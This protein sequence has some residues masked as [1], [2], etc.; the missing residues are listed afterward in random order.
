MGKTA[1]FVISVLEQLKDNTTPG[2][3]ALVVAHTR[4]L[5]TQIRDEFL[6]FRKH[7]N[8]IRVAVFLGG[9]NVDQDIETLKDPP[10]IVIGTPG[11]LL[12]LVKDGVLDLSKL[13][14]FVLDECDSC[15]DSLG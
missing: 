3:I 9:I 12:S 2:V 10:Q 7:M 5:A 6:S 13:K 11:R 8:N 1:V 15:L 4:E 14:H